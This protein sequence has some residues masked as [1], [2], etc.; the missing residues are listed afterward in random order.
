MVPITWQMPLRLGPK[1]YCNACWEYFV[2]AWNTPKKGIDRPENA[3][4]D[5]RPSILEHIRH[6]AIAIAFEERDKNRP[7]VQTSYR[8]HGDEKRFTPAQQKQI[9]TF[10]FLLRKHIS[11]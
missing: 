3:S 2:R 9:E 1:F 7:P 5:W 6:A 8:R 4:D 11:P 10:R